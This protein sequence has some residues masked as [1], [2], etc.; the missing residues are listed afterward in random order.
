MTPRADGPQ[1]R[2][3]A[4]EWVLEPAITARQR[5]KVLSANPIKA[6]PGG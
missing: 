3:S 2:R 6:G 5:A 1:E 4:W